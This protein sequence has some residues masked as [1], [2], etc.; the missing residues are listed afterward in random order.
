MIR[1]HGNYS[2]AMGTFYLYDVKTHT[3]MARLGAQVGLKDKIFLHAEVAAIIK[4]RDISKAH[5]IFV[6]RTMKDGSMGLAKPCPV[7]AK[8]IQLSGIKIIQHT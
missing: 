1:A 8:A 2:S 7:C 6:S 5:R 3:M 4:C